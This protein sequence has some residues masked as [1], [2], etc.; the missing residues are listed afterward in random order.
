MVMMLKDPRNSKVSEAGLKVRTGRKL[1]AEEAESRLR[2]KD[3]IRAVYVEW[4]ALG[5]IP[6]V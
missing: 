5:M 6:S 2:H 3:L 4:Q 1:K